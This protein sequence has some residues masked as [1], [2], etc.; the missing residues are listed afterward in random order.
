MKKLPRKLWQK[1]LLRGWYQ[2]VIRFKPKR[3]V[4]LNDMAKSQGNKTWYLENGT[5]IHFNP[6]YIIKL[7]VK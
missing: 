2:M 1:I 6:D 4:T 7:E 5:E 3:K